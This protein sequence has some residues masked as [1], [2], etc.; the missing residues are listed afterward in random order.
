MAGLGGADIL[1]KLIMP[2][3]TFLVRNIQP[4]LAKEGKVN[5][6]DFILQ[7]TRRVHHSLPVI[8]FQ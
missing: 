1:N 7:R 8:F 5:G 6:E 2:L 4:H 3:I